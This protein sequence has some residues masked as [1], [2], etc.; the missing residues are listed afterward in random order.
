M[1]NIV[2]HLEA[3]A[4][5]LPDQVFC[6]FLD[7]VGRVTE[8]LT[9]RQ[10]DER[11]NHV[12]ARLIETGK[13]RAGQPVLLVYAPGLDFIVAF[14]ACVKTGTIPV[15]VPPAEPSG[16][17]VE[18][19]FH[20]A[21]D[22]GAGL[23]LTHDA[24]IRQQKWLADDVIK[25]EPFHAP[26]CGLI[27]LST[28]G[29]RGELA[30]FAGHVNPTLF[31]QYTSGS[32][33]SP[34]GVVVSH[35]NVIHNCEAVLRHRPIGVSWLP[36]YHDM[37]LIGYYLF[38]MLKAGSVFTFSGA[39]FLRRPLLW[40]ET[41]TQVKATITSAPNFAYEYCVRED[42]VPQQALDNLDLSSVRVMMNAAEPVRSSTCDRF[43]AKFARCGLSSR[44]LVVFYGLAENTLAVTGDGRVRLTVNAKQLE[45]NQ[46]RIEPL[47]A[48]G[49]NQTTLV[50]CG[51]PLAGIE[52]RVVNSD[53]GIAVGE[54]QVGEVWTTGK[55]KA[56]GYFNKPAVNA[57]VFC[58]LIDSNAT[59]AYLRTGD[60]GF[61]HDG[62]LF[63]CGR[64]KD[65]IVIGGRNYYPN[66]I[67]AVVERSSVKIRQG[68][69]AALA[70][71]RKDSEAIAVI[72]EVAKCNDVPDLKLIWQQIRRHCQV[73]VAL[74]AIV[75]HGAI[76]RT[77]SGKIA[78]LE[79]RRRLNAGEIT[80]LASLQGSPPASGDAFI[81]DFVTRFDH[82]DL[83]HHTLAEVGVDSLT[84]VELSVCIEREV[85]AAS[86]IQNA[87]WLEAV[88]DLRI[89]QTV[90]VRELLSFLRGLAGD[91]RRMKLSPVQYARRLRHVEQEEFDLMRR[92]TMLPREVRP[93]TGRCSGDG[94]LLLTGATGFL[95][96]H[97]L[98]ALLRL[99]NRTI[100]TLVRAH[101]DEHARCRVRAGLQRYG[102]LLGELRDVFEKQVVVLS[103]DVTEPDLGLCRSQWDALAREVSS[104]YHCA[105]EVDYVKSY[106]S[107]RGPNVTGTVGII[108]LA[109]HGTTKV[110]HFVSTTFIFGFS[111]RTICWEHECN[112]EMA[113]LTFGYPQTKWVAEQLVFEAARR[114]LP[115][116]VYRPSFVSA[117]SLGQYVR[118][119]LMTRTFAYMIRHGIS[120]NATNQMSLLPV[121]VC[122]NNL[123]ALSLLDDPALPVFHLTSDDY[124]T[125]RHACSAISHDFGYSFK[126]LDLEAAVDHMN[127][128]C[129]KDDPLF[130]LIAF[131]NHNHRRIGRMRHK[132]YDNRNYRMTRAFSASTSPEPSLQA[133]MRSVVHF[134][135]RENLVPGPPHRMSVGGGEIALQA[136]A[137]L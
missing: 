118:R 108:R 94:K 32:T 122:A 65:M 18:K 48:D 132:R 44:A 105:A 90:T 16:V 24:Y 125:M 53:T 6:T 131:Y 127:Q 38:I 80:I 4:H 22:S 114:G 12:A 116:R 11:S 121:D 29:M 40:F 88:F 66:D 19:L 36:H 23:A 41:I 106:R 74:L 95:G 37:G 30:R 107:L 97:I 128:H 70:I 76:A 111:P 124:Y 17:G 129:R 15:P 45:Q 69:V 35:G 68:R 56:H 27:W 64:L 109:A 47:K 110:M 1:K 84:L 13:I 126:Y 31:L 67:E 34:R 96:A 112:Q 7:G 101:D 73:E 78:R 115:T 20:V 46:V 136:A 72:A 93:E 82:E 60:L 120:T 85:K 62:E 133:T 51:K 91:D 119:D 2:D 77:S 113:D 59:K 55:S 87:R 28:D 58:A 50:S 54:D 43:L 79:C 33:Q 21:R 117:S 103:G 14:M 100:V 92:D 71:Q 3:T 8:S 25:S 99:T 9:Y 52:V 63:I 26:P 86:P 81:A 5:D 42:K 57:A 137:L 75:P 102:L 61:L 135:Q 83:H 10:L 104:V 49:Y 123:V 134:L 130:P 89:L 98:A 39:N